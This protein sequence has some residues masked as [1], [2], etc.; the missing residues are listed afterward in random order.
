MTPRQKIFALTVGIMLFV[1][2][3]E[4]VRRRAL[5][6]EYSWLWLATGAGIVLLAVWYDLLLLITD[7]IGA[8]LPTTTLFLFGMLFLVLI[9]LHYAVK[10]SALTDQVR[11]L[12]QELA[13]ERAQ[14][15]PADIPPEPQ[16]DGPDGRQ[17]SD[18]DFKKAGA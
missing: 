7:L 1:F 8:V 11:R 9:N 17:K 16:E 2:I 14:K 3:V 15:K 18:S 13:I 6:E 12:A 5:K 4:L 10:I